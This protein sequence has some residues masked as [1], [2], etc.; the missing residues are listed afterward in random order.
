M[1]AVLHQPAAAAPDAEPH[2][3]VRI[4][5]AEPRHKAV[6][7]LRKTTAGYDVF[8]VDGFVFKR[9]RKAAEAQLEQI[10]APEHPEPT[11]NEETPTPT[12]ENEVSHLE[13]APATAGL[14][15]LP[16]AL[17]GADLLAACREAATSALGAVEAD[18][19]ATAE[20]AAQAWLA[21]VEGATGGLPA[22]EPA[23]VEAAAVCEEEEAE[24]HA[25]KS[26]LR[27]ILARMDAEERDWLALQGQLEDRQAPCEEAL[28]QEME[29][30]FTQDEGTQWAAESLLAARAGAHRKLA[31]QVEAYAGLV[32]GVEAL[33]STAEQACSAMQAEYHRDKFRAFP[34]VDSPATLIKGIAKRGQP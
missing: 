32:G 15:P 27:T 11:Q 26:M 6:P 9:K 8:E 21:A 4:E 34:H 30:A 10:A 18:V 7:T 25:K 31:L 2:I 19:R 24:L 13:A 33:L 5:V 3:R 1:A 22:A 17:S 14:E 23:A 12:P 20:A 29:G 28:W 16:G